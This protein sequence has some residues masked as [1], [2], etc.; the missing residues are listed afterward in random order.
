M[1]TNTHGGGSRML[2]G[3]ASCVMELCASMVHMHAAGMWVLSTHSRLPYQHAWTRLGKCH[4][5]VPVQLPRQ[6]NQAAGAALQPTI[7]HREPADRA[8]Q[9][10][11]QA[12]VACCCMLSRCCTTE[13]MRCMHAR[14]HE[15]GCSLAP[16]VRI[17]FVLQILYNKS[18]QACGGTHMAAPLLRD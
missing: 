17:G 9:G 10:D 15:P 1:P 4:R 5:W 18:S 16:R 8:Y 14:P 2:I 11:C 6:H 7:L 13:G 3:S 12:T